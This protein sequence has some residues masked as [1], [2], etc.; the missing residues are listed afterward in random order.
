MHHALIARR[1]GELH[2]ERGLEHSGRLYLAEARQALLDWGAAA[3]AAELKRTHPFLRVRSIGHTG[4]GPASPS[5]VLSPA[6]LTSD[7]IDT[8]AILR[9][10]QALA[11]QTTMAQLHD[12]IVD[13]LSAIT[14]ATALQLVLPRE[15]AGW[16]IR[17][18]TTDAAGDPSLDDACAATLLPVSAVRY[19]LR[20]CATLAVDDATSDDRFT[21]DPYLAGKQRLAL[22]VVPVLRSGDLRAILVLENHLATG[23]FTHDRLD[24]ST[25]SPASSPSPWTT[26]C[27][28]PRS[29]NDRRTDRGSALGQRAAGTAQRHR[30]PDRRGQPAQLRHR[31]GG[32]MDPLARPT[33]L[34]DHGRRHIQEHNDHHGHPAGDAC[35]IEISRL[36]ARSLRGADILCRYGGEEFTAILPRADLDMAVAV[37]ERMRRTVENAALPHTPA[38]GTV[39]I[40]VGVASALASRSIPASELLTRADA[41]LYEAKHAGRNCVRTHP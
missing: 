2:R 9:V 4:I 41:A 33:H 19:V 11:A 16:R 5:T 10:A 26:R 32:R 21:R 17:R 35:L 13:Q 40:S 18:T 6:M 27:S 37:A 31:T 24:A 30:R 20:T 3:F 14:G 28:T 12:T 38:I 29:N 34:C 25:C 7:A 22:L 39:T 15:G 1:A 8:T 36:L 23:T